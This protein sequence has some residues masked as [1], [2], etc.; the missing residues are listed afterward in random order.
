MVDFSL[1]FTVFNN[2]FRV[3]SSFFIC[4][5]A[6]ANESWPAMLNVLLFFS[7]LQNNSF[8]PFV[9][10]ILCTLCISNAFWCIC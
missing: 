3:C 10:G 1:S 6:F 8:S 9:M 2:S 5:V 4:A 7:I